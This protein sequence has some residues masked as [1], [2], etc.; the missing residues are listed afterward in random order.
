MQPSLAFK[1]CALENVAFYTKH[2][3]LFHIYTTLKLEVLP[4]RKSLDFDYKCEA[5][6]VYTGGT[7]S[8]ECNSAAK[9]IWQFCI[10]REIC[11]SAALIP[12]KK[13]TQAESRVFVGNKRWNC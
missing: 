4:N 8:I 6:A 11:I 7:H 12:G 5:N 13:N 10:E 1:L 3:F 2:D 9:D